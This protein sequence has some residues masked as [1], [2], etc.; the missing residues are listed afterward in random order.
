MANAVPPN[1]TLQLG[2]TGWKQ[3]LLVGTLKGQRLD[4]TI[5]SLLNI[6]TIVSVKLG[7]TGWKQQ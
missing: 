4:T 3:Q 7:G 5:V 6:L 2:G 1:L